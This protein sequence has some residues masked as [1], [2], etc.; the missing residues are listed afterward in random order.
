MSFDTPS[1]VKEVL[2]R[3]NMR[4]IHGR[5]QNFLVD[6][7]VIQKIIKESSI[8]SSEYILEIGPG[9]GVLTNELSGRA[10]KVLTIDIDKNIINLLEQEFEWPNVSILRKDILKI[11]N[12]DI[13]KSL[14]SRKYKLISNLPYQI[15]SEVIEKF[16]TQE[17]RPAEIILMI[18]REVG[19]RILTSA[20]HA[21]LLSLM[22]EFYAEPKI[23]FRVSKNS[24]YPVPKV[25]SVIMK[26][27]PKDAPLKSEE[28]KPFWEMVRAG[29]RSKRKYLFSNLSSYTKY[30]KDELS[31]AWDSLGMDRKI[32]PESLSLGEWLKL[33]SK[34]RP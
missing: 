32:R 28:N 1:T 29:F 5:G 23:L 30:S 3:Y 13:V 11:S 19:E 14:G 20:P 24:F 4:P 22:V 34:I 16:L 33:F 12:A 10:K 15:T 6:K 27:I 31:L 25:D 9:L 17:P 7:N 21:N 26:F 8:K 18:Q 2:S